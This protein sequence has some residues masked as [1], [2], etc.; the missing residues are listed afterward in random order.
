MSPPL[1][2]AP[3]DR[4]PWLPR[5]TL[6][7]CI[8]LVLVLGICGQMRLYYDYAWQLMSIRDHARGDTDSPFVMRSADHADLSRDRAEWTIGYPLGYNATGAILTMSGLTAEA[9]HR[10]IA[11][12]AVAMGLLGWHVV[13][14]RC[15]GLPAAW[16][17]GAL[18]A[19][20]LSLNGAGM[21]SFMMPEVFLFAAVPWQ[22]WAFWH[23]T[24]MDSP[25][26]W[27]HRVGGLLGFATGL[28]Y[29]FRYVG[30]LHGLPLVAVAAL[31]L[32]WRRPRGWWITGLV[33][34]LAA[35]LPVAVMSILNYRHVGA[36]NSTSS[37]LPWGITAQWPDLLHWLLV[38]AGPFQAL[39]VSA[40]VFDRT[41]GLIGEAVFGL[42]DF[43]SLKSLS[44]SLALVPTTLAAILIARFAVRDRLLLGGLAA[45]AGTILGL[46]WLYSHSGLPQPDTR[47]SV[48]P[49]LL[50]WPVLV[51]AIHAAWR[52]T[53]RWRVALALLAMPAGPALLIAARSHQHA[54]EPLFQGRAGDI[55]AGGRVDP[56]ALRAA[57]NA[58]VGP[59]DGGIVWMCFQPG[60]LYSL[61]GRHIFE[62]YGD[63]PVAF[64]SRRPVTVVV[65]RDQALGMHPSTYANNHAGLAI[66]GRPPDLVHGD[67]DVFIRRIGP[68]GLIQPAVKQ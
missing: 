66:E 24:S 56:A 23:V 4:F 1:N 22:M 50:L 51:G 44:L 58:R 2:P 57:L 60:V 68:A 33:L 45:L 55:I 19:I 14:A 63:S 34:G 67:F 36:I 38:V 61:D 6:A 54:L 30:A 26:P 35:L 7:G 3:A 47:Y 49:A 25:A 12:G 31:W 21:M 39:F 40:H 59:D 9:A 10:L 41:A 52:G 27:R 18:A 16:R 15:T 28:A 65:L 46:L 13:F 62:A 29:T 17:A 20:G 5:A 43:G 42:T 53:R 37:S 8:F 32:L 64:R 48:A 11:T